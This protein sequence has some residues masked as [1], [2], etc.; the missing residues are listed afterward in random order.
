MCGRLYG[1]PERLGELCSTHG[2]KV[3]SYYVFVNKHLPS[4]YMRNQKPRTD[5]FISEMGLLS[6]RCISTRIPEKYM[7]LLDAMGA[8]RA[9]WLRQVIVGA[10]EK[11]PP[12]P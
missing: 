12:A 1:K 8:D 11:L 9:R 6:A 7:P 2:Y 3:T 5:H 4:F 10:L